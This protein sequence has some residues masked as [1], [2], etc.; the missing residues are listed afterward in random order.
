MSWLLKIVS[1]GMYKI[2]FEVGWFE[3]F[4]KKNL[5]YFYRLLVVSF[6]DVLVKVMIW[7]KLIFVWKFNF[8]W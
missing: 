8:L 5:E 7:N 2:F 6:I 4:D 3:E 1:I